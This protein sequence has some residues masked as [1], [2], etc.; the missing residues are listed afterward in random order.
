LTKD[1]GVFNWTVGSPS[2]PYLSITSGGRRL[3]ELAIFRSAPPFWTT[4]EAFSRVGPIGLVM[5][6]P[7]THHRRRVRCFPICSTTCHFQPPYVKG[8]I[9]Q[10]APENKTKKKTEKFLVAVLGNLCL[11]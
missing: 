5:I 8:A 2:V 7:T 6:V 3:N 10:L 4:L 1:I 11:S 9:S